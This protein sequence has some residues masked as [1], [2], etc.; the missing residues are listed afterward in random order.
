[1]SEGCRVMGNWLECVGRLSVEV[2]E[3]VWRGGD[4]VWMEQAGCL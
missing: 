1:M 3:A 2:G 4:T